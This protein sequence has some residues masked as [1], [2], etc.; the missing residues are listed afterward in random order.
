M[1]DVRVVAP[2][3]GEVVGDSPQR[4]VEILCDQRAVHATVSRFAA[5]R[6]GADLHIHRHHSDLFYVLEGELT[7]RLVPEDVAVGAG[8]L[9]CVPPLVVHGFKN[10][11]ERA[12]SDSSSVKG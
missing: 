9:V 7:L 3:G 10:A 6:A 5:G 12:Q 2:G 4:R 8:T 11:G 1:S